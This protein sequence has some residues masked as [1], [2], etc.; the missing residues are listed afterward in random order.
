ME[1]LIRIV[2]RICADAVENRKASK[3]GDIVHVAPDGW[4]WGSMELINP[5][6]RIVKFP[7]VDHTLWADMV[8]PEYQ[9]TIE[10]DGMPKWILLRKRKKALD[11]LSDATVLA[12]LQSAPQVYTVTE[13][14]KSKI[15]AIIKVKPAIG[16]VVIG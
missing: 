11:F 8:E 3:A 9:V 5:E 15:A 16:Q 2:D 13:Q 7:G 10:P 14:Q 6:W 4:P 1:I 12:F